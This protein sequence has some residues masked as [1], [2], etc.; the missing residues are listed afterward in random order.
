MRYVVDRNVVMRRMNVLLVLISVTGRGDVQGHSAAGRIMSMP[1]SNDTIVNRTRDLPACSAVPQTTEPPRERGLLFRAET[2]VQYWLI[3]ATTLVR[4]LVLETNLNT[5]QD[6]CHTVARKYTLTMKTRCAK[7]DKMKRL[8]ATCFV[9]I[10]Y[11]GCSATSKCLLPATMHGPFA[12]P[13]NHYLTT[14]IIHNL[15]RHSLGV[16]L[17]NSQGRYNWIQGAAS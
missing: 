11:T 13:H 16:L 12:S 9:W 8:P 1:N 17:S 6:H 10:C 2:V 15:W 7:R 3:S 4:H 5:T 14:A